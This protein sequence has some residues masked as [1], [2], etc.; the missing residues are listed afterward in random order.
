MPQT[1]TRHDNRAGVAQKGEFT[2]E[3]AAISR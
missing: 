3:F 2:I 1:L